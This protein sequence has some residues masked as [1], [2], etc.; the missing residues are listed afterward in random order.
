MRRREKG[1]REDRDLRMEGG[2]GGYP[3]EDEYGDAGA[4]PP[5]P[6]L[7]PHGSE[8]PLNEGEGAGQRRGPPN[9]KT[10]DR[11]K[12]FVGGLPWALDKDALGELFRKFG[13]LKDVHVLRKQDGRSRGFGFVKFAEESSV[14]LAISELHDTEIDGR[15]IS[16]RLAT[17][18]Q[19]RPDRGDRGGRDGDRGRDRDR[20]RDGGYRGGYEGDRYGPPP[21]RGGYGGGR[22]RGVPR[23]GGAR[24][25]GRGSH[26]HRT[27]GRGGG[28]RQAVHR[29]AAA[30]QGRR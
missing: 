1:E 16:V 9:D 4:P 10:D 22:E 13:E 11:F 19:E 17:E 12:V 8:P 23:A 30:G 6:P 29:R 15:R 3:G 14:Q 28:L 2:E 18:R 24:G 5:P 7:E 21:G 25:A 20:D 27:E 26:H